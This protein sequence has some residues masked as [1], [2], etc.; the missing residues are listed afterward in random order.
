MPVRLRGV[1]LTVFPFRGLLFDLDGTLVN[2]L[3]AVDRAWRQWAIEF[4]LDPD[5]VVPR[6]HGRRA[7]E[8]IAALGPQL[9]QDKAFA[10]LEHL[11]ATDTEGVVALVGA[12]DLLASLQ[13][14]PWGIVTSGSRPIAEPRLRAGG[15]KPPSVF[16]TAEDVLKG[17]PH[18]DP[19]L[20]GANRLGLAPN[21]V[22]AFEDTL[23][24]IRSAQ[25]AGMVAIGVSEEAAQ[26]A[27]A[28]I[29]DYTQLV[30]QAG[31]PTSLLR[32]K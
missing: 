19:F 1:S 16:V 12:L 18:P 4:G 3:P 31:N 7:V 17:K 23:A 9:D 24:G 10:R 21:E 25:A 11:E 5:Y 6:I 22:I 8:S 29:S 14:I 2:S 30:I 20:E 26:E 27:D 15:I 13:D 28:S 32:L